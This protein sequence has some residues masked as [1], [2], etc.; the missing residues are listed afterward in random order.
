MLEAPGF[1]YAGDFCQGQFRLLPGWSRQ[2]GVYIWAKDGQ[3]R[4]VVRVGIACGTGGFGARFALHNKWLR[5]DFKRDDPREQ[6]VRRFTLQGLG[7]RAEVWAAAQPDREVAAELERLVRALYG[8]RLQVD[9][10]VRD[11]WIK[12][13]MDEW[14]RS[15][16]PMLRD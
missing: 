4:D 3:P 16:R 11:S 8:R 5:G 12:K 13:Q 6:A 2:S 9:L 15:G 10:S 1:S 14:R 7:D